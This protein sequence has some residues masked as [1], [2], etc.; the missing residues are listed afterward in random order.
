MGKCLALKILSLPYF[1]VWTIYGVKLLKEEKLD[2]GNFLLCLRDREVITMEIV[3]KFL[4]IDTDKEI[5]NY[6][7]GH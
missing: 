3:G 1:V 4:G 6:F 7:R 5:W 2:K